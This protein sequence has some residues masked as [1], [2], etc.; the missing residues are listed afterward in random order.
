MINFTL[1]LFLQKLTNDIENDL[2][3]M[4]SFIIIISLLYYHTLSYIGNRQENL[5]QKRKD[6][7]EG[8]FL[9]LGD[10]FLVAPIE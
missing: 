7:E 10:V 2:S 8:I 1:Y 5:H 6:I 4:S 3:C 9:P